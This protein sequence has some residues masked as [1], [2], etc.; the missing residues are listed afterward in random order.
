MLRYE[1]VA[2]SNLINTPPDKS[3]APVVDLN[4]INSLFSQRVSSTEWSVVPDEPTT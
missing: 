2:P 4:D 1:I 3:G